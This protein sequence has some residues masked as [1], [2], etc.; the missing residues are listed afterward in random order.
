MSIRFLS[1]IEQNSV[2]WDLEN[3][4]FLLILI[5]LISLIAPFVLFLWGNLVIRTLV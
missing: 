1:I 4:F 3:S 2:Q 5:G